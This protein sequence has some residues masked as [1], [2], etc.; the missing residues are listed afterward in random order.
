MELFV[1]SL[2]L[3]STQ[4][5]ISR[6]AKTLTPSHMKQCILSESRFDFLKDLVKDIPDASAQEDSENNLLFD[7]TMEG[8]ESPSLSTAN[9]CNRETSQDE[10]K[11]PSTVIRYGPPIPHDVAC[12]TTSSSTLSRR[13][14]RSRAN[15]R[16]N[17][18][19]F[20][21]ETSSTH[22]VED[23]TESEDTSDGDEKPAKIPK[24]I[25][26]DVPPLIPILNQSKN[27]VLIIDEDYDN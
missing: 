25:V 17:S 8:V 11:K 16:S 18:N 24:L 23:E 3:K 20:K 22:S 15:S 6:N 27:D 5:T 9:S 2:L 12:A 26:E 7:A 19:S 21:R 4:I 14:S 10:N 1:E 13:T